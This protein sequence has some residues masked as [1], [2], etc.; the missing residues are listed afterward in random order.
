MSYAEDGPA[1]DPEETRTRP[2]RDRDAPPTVADRID[3]LD[4]LLHVIGEQVDR[5]SERLSPIL[6]PERPI[7]ALAGGGGADDVSSE[8]SARLS[9]IAGHADHLGRGLRE[10]LDRVDL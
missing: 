4:K 9:R 7:P 10:L 5:A 1:Y 2:M 6:R 8:V 3:Q